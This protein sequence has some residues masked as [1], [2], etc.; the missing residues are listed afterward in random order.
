M[1]GAG[2][3][4]VSTSARGY[5]DWAGLMRGYC[6]PKYHDWRKLYLHGSTATWRSSPVN[7]RQRP[8]AAFTSCECSNVHLHAS[9]EAMIWALALLRLLL[10]VAALQLGVLAGG[11]HAVADALGVVVDQT[12]VIR[13]LPAPTITINHHRGS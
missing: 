11:G 7:V 12:P 1:C 13:E 10:G 4:E 5:G 8:L 9:V 6:L 3:G 2:V